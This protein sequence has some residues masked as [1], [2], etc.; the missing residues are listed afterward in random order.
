MKESKMERYGGCLVIRI[1]SELDHHQ[2]DKI[3]EKADALIERGG[4]QNVIFDFSEVS[5]MD[6]AGIGMLT[7]RYKKVQYMGGKIY[8]AGVEPAVDR[9]LKMTGIYKLV[10][11]YDSVQEI[12]SKI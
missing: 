7:G 4:I 12:M 6:S 9:I 11:K 2:V 1:G 3:R 10:K 8:V 5:F